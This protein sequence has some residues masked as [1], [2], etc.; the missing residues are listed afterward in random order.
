MYKDIISGLHKGHTGKVLQESE[1]SYTMKIA[2]DK[3]II[4]LKERCVESE[5]KGIVAPF[6]A[7]GKKSNVVTHLLLREKR[8]S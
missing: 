7:K 4:V 8:N 5:K 1:N 3:E 6:V 2:N